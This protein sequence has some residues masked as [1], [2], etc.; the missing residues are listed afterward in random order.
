MRSRHSGWKA[1]VPVLAA[2]GALATAGCAAPPKAPVALPTPAERQAVDWSAVIADVD[3]GIDVDFAPIGVAFTN[4]WSGIKT[5]GGS[6]EGWTRADMH[7]VGQ[8]DVEGEYQK[9]VATPVAQR[10]PFNVI[11]P[12]VRYPQ[13]PGTDKD[14]GKRNDVAV[15]RWWTGIPHPPERGT[16]HLSHYEAA[17]WQ[18]Y[19]ET[20]AWD[21]TGPMPEVT[22]NEMNLMKAEGLINQ[23]NGAAAA[24]LVNITRVGNGELTP[25]TGMGTVPTEPGGGCVPHPRFDTAGTCGDLMEAMKYEYLTEVFQVSAGI[26]FW[27]LRGWGD[28]VAGTVI[29]LPIPGEELEVLQMDLY[30]FGGVGNPGGAPG[31][32]ESIG[33]SMGELSQGG[34]EVALRRAAYSLERLRVLDEQDKN[35]KPVVVDY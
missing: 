28:L 11:T 29:H 8:A 21:W 30:T 27:S 15:F 31:S 1:T 24:A 26:S 19:K 18:T 14:V 35:R 20:S 34:L 33:P 25:V 22:V 12:D 2:L 9:W 23:G 17:H 5:L 16:Y 3:N 32:N 13:N 10:Q 4:W 6:N 7:W